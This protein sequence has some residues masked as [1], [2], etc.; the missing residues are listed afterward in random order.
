MSAAPGSG[1][2]FGVF[3]PLGRFFELTSLAR[4]DR[5]E[6]ADFYQVA[7]DFNS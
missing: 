3:A 2:S 4:R 6:L 5:Y 1:Y 7:L